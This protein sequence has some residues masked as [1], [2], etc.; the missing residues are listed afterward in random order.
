MTEEQAIYR[1]Y[2]QDNGDIFRERSTT[3]I[4][5]GEEESGN[6]LICMFSR[7]RRFTIKRG[8]R[9]GFI[10]VVRATVT[11]EGEFEKVF[12]RR[13]GTVEETNEITPNDPI[14]G[15]ST[16]DEEGVMKE[17]LTS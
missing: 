9:R 1:C 15:K 12:T 17:N 14:S 6:V 13:N 7:L 10:T 3:Q 4:S 5:S 2:F 11:L 8:S 16:T